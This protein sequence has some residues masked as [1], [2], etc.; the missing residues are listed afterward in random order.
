MRSLGAP[1]E[2]GLAPHWLGRIRPHGAGGLL[3]ALLAAAP[4]AAD[5]HVVSS[6][7]RGMIYGMAACAVGF[8]VR[9]GGM[10]SFGHAAYF[11]IGA[12]TVLIA[13][14]LGT[15]SALIVWPCAV[16]AAVLASL[17]IG[18]LSLR[19]RG[20]SFIMITLAFAQ[21]AYF[22]LS[23]IQ[24]IGGSDGLGLGGRSTLGFV[25]LEGTAAF[26]F[27]VLGLLAGVLLLLSRVARS[28]F[29]LAL[30]GI[31]QNERRLAALG[32][33]TVRLQLSAFALSAAITGLAGALAAEFY[34]FV[35]PGH[36]HWTL[37]GELLVMA[38]LGGVTTLT[39]GL[40]GALAL[41]LAEVLLSELT[42]YWRVILGPVVI[43]A[44]LYLRQGLQPALQKLLGGAHD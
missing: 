35:S 16:L 9:Y 8:I 3:L 27:V 41:L 4:L 37:S 42:T 6:V 34:M 2:S 30:A 31:R 12:Y 24:E 25:S 32:Y 14:L 39:G 17:F 15:T 36:L 13:H 43:V 33:D 26:H 22:I 21:M 38:T 10:V 40:F 29:G 11:G 28:D 20:V 44:V 7:T 18:A 1:L 23:S 19:T 5:S